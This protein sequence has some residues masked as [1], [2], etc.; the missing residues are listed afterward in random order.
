[1]YATPYFFFDMPVDIPQIFMNSST[2]V[3][4]TEKALGMCNTLWPVSG[5]HTDLHQQQFRTQPKV[6]DASNLSE[7]HFQG[8]KC[9]LFF[10]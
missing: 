7:L 6:M 3:L 8:T 9:S 5:F 1:M 4:A 10:Y 2:S